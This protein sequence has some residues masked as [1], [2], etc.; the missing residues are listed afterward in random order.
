MPVLSNVRLMEQLALKAAEHERQKIAR[1]L[2]DSVIQPYI[3]IQMGLAGLRKAAEGDGVLSQKIERLIKMTETG[4]IDLRNYIGG[5]SGNGTHKN[6][7]LPGVR[8]FAARF[9]EATGINVEVRSGNEEMCINDRLA[10]EAFQIV[11]EGLSNIRRHSHATQAVITIGCTDRFFIMSIE[12]NNPTE[13]TTP[14]FTPQTITTRSQ[15]LG[16]SA[17]VTRRP[18]GGSQVE[19]EI[20]L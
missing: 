15:A 13:E 7:L 10:A 16:G 8:R 12:N 11:T 20:P 4:I 9:A 3:G 17:R 5:M 6:S 14:L 18:S 2:H 19:I 1:D